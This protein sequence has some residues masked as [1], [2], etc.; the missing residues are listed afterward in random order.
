MTNYSGTREKVK[1]GH[2]KSSGEN[3]EETNKVFSNNYLYIVS[4]M[5]HPNDTKYILLVINFIYKR[6]NCNEAVTITTT[7]TSAFNVS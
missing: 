4:T 7:I 6:S 1:N 5:N 2:K 3:C